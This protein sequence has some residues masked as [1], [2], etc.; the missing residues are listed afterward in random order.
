[1]TKRSRKETELY[2][3]KNLQPMAG[4]LLIRRMF[5]HGMIALYLVLFSL[6][7]GMGGY[8][9]FEHLS[10][11]DAFLHA[12]MIL[13]GM[14]PVATITSRGGKI[15]AGFYALYSGLIFLVVAG[16]LMAPVVHRVLHRFHWEI[17]GDND[18]KSDK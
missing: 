2:E 7:L 6:V 9:G 8:M 3:S 11:V 17:S 12:S 4:H 15:F 16:L 10:V 1:M 13:G 14:G 18:N 5:A